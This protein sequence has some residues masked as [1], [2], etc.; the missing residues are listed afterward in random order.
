MVYG[1]WTSGEGQGRNILELGFGNVRLR[2]DL[3]D[4]ACCA[5]VNDGVRWRGGELDEYSKLPY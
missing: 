3:E 5:V 1:L 4:E 2:N